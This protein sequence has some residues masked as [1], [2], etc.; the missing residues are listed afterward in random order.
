LKSGTSVYQ[1]LFTDT[2]VYG[3]GSIVPRVF[4]FFLV[5]LHTRVFGP[6]AYG[7]ITDTYGWIAILNVVF[8]FGM[9]TAYLRYATR[10]G[11]D[12]K[13]AFQA[14]QTV[15][16]GISLMALLFLIALIN[17]DFLTI[18]AGENNLLTYAAVTLVVDAWCALPFVRLRLRNESKKFALLKI[19]NVSLLV[20]LNLWYLSS[21]ST[22]PEQVF[23]ANML[24]NLFFLFYFLPVLLQWR[25]RWEAALVRPMVAYSFPVM[26]TGLAGMTNEMFSRISIDNWLPDGFYKGYS[27]EYVQGIFGA[28]YKFAVLMSLVVQAFRMAA[29]PFFFSRAEQ[30]D[31]PVVFAKVNH[32]FTVVAV[33]FLMAIC[34]NLNWL[35]FL[36]D[37]RYWVGLVIVPWLLLG[38]LFLGV[39][40]NMTVWFKI[41]DRTY[42]GTVITSIGAVATIGLNFILI[43]VYGI[44]GSA[45]VT[46][47]VYF[48]MTVICYWFG[49]KYFP[50]PYTLSK[51]LALVFIS[52]VIIQL[53]GLLE[54]E[55]L[56]A[57]GC[58]I[59]ATLASGGI[60]WLTEK[61]SLRSKISA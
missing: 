40:Y 16:F 11:G 29:E 33:F 10:S 7:R 50:I 5:P 58:G 27:S 46:F 12:E 48:L 53:Y 59:L 15:I 56:T 47:L 38:Y 31:S 37:E 42:F 41:T 39:Y 36:V 49:Q 30:K 8:L 25:P 24:A 2:A 18:R 3:L 43:P 19:V 22:A 51:D 55:G 45:V 32:Y 60:L 34:F 13:K 1:K 44:L 28:C 26:L 17:L 61:D 20:G 9:E 35:R 52:F 54:I 21:D 57:I 14:A 4:N 23:L 6:E